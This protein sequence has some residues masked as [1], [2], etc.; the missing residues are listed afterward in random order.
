ME[1]IHNYSHT[2]IIGNIYTANENNDFVEALILEKETIVFLGKVEDGHNY[3]EQNQIKK[4]KFM[5]MGLE[6][7]ALPGFIDSH[8]HPLA[9]GMHSLGFQVP[10]CTTFQELN[11]MVRSFID[12]H[13][14]DLWIIGL[15]YN[16]LQ[17]KD[18]T[19]IHFSTID[20]IC[21]DK[22]VCI[23]RFDAHAY[24]LNTKALEMTGLLGPNPPECPRGGTIDIKNG[25]LH[26][27]A[28]SIVRKSL[29]KLP[30]NVKVKIFKEVS[31]YLFSFGITAFMDAAVRQ[32]N[33]YLFNELYEDKELAKMLPRMSVSITFRS[34]GFDPETEEEYEVDTHV[35]ACLS[36]LSKFFEKNRIPDWNDNAGNGKY[37]VNTVKL[38]IDGVFES[39]TA[40]YK[41]CECG[42]HKLKQ[43]KNAPD[44][45]KEELIKIFSYLYPNNIQIHCHCIGDLAT[46]IVLDAYENTYELLNNSDSAQHNVI[47]YIAHLQL[48]E[49]K[50]ILRIQK[51]NLGANFS[52][53]WFM[54]DDL[55]SVLEKM[56][57]KER[58]KDIYPIKSMKDKNINICFGSDWS[59]SSVNPLEGI[60]VAVTHRGLSVSD[61]KPSY[62]PD[63]MISIYDAIKAYTIGSAKVLN[64]DKLVGSLEVGK[65]GDIIIINKNIF[66]MEPWK[67][68]TAQVVLTMSNGIV[69][70]DKNKYNLV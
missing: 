28:M 30:K 27:S 17:F 37:R 62:N 36:S 60:E 39:G 43:D 66:N 44:Y 34:P 57:G 68:H 70:Y 29:P 23:M 2:F 59:V 31:E 19:Q 10:D 8:V 45:T 63:Q 26:D 11:D 18:G 58:I 42:E 24:W 56:I 54:E 40:Y 64:L 5:K 55:C 12:T 38:F 53:L 32:T 21:S 1:N 50:D 41:K 47:D 49:E 52:P 20:K 25:I 65:K 3:L 33:H 4:V 13:Q 16:D 46:Q 48:V 9:A 6:E 35:D 7:V 69:V 61:D 51:L 15:G 22:P 14:E 67:I